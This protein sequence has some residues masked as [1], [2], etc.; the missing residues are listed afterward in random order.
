MRRQALLIFTTLALCCL[1]GAGFSAYAQFKEGA[2]TQNYNDSP[3]DGKTAQK[4]TT[5]QLFSFKELFRGLG[6]K[7]EISVGTMFAG[8]VMLPGSGQIYNRDYWKLP[9]VYGGI[10]AFATTGG[11][12]THRYKQSVSAGTPNIK[13]KQIATWMW[14]GTGLTYWGSLMDATFCFDRSQKPLPGRAAAYSALLPGLGQAY[15]GEYWKVPFYYSG[16]MAAGWFWHTNNVNYKRFKR[17]HN[18]ITNTEIE[19]TGPSNITAETAKY[20]RDTYRRY[21]DYSIVATV[22]VYVLQVIDANV[23]AYMHDFEV[24]DDITMR[25]EPAII[26]PDNEYAMSAPDYRRSAVGLKVGLRF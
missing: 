3:A 18:E 22:L 15:N 9:I 7:Q 25:M 13:Y 8:A 11:I 5:D 20:Y 21:R 12:Y 2:F 6:H 1:S 19:Y 23:F 10:A 26:V 16:L 4:D 24:N 17:I 14:V